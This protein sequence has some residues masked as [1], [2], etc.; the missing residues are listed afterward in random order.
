M[1][2]DEML[3]L[4]VNVVEFDAKV[5]DQFNEMLIRLASEVFGSGHVEE[6]TQPDL[7]RLAHDPF[8]GF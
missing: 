7:K 3:Q 5:A 2:A 4:D 1:A 8:G 6:L